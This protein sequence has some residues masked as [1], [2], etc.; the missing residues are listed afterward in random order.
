MAPYE[1]LVDLIISRRN[2]KH[3]GITFILGDTDERFVS[4]GDIYHKSLGLLS[5]LQ[6]LGFLPGDQV[7]FQIDDNQEFI[8]SFWACI[9]GG[10]YRSRSPPAPMMS[11]S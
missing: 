7:V 2:E 5:R 4:Y 3:T 11:I 9:M 6:E 8:Y 10:I 1:T